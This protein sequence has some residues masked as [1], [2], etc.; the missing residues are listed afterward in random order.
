MVGDTLDD[1]IE[2][3]LAVGM[4]AVLLDREGRHPDRGPARATCAG[5]PAALG[6]RIRL[7]GRCEGAP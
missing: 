5:S 6:L 7:R 4:R 3:A 2:G 1:D